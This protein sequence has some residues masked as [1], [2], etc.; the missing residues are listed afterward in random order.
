MNLNLNITCV[1]R[2]RIQNAEEA[3]FVTKFAAADKLTQINKPQPQVQWVLE[4]EC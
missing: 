4:E 1:L 2:S 3:C